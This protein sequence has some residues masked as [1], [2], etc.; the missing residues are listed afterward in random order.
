MF[1]LK[2]IISVDI[3]LHYSKRNNPVIYF[4]YWT[5]STNK[6]FEAFYI[7]GRK[8]IF[9]K[10]QPFVL[11][12]VLKWKSYIN[13]INCFFFLFFFKL[14]L[15][16]YHKSFRLFAVERWFIVKFSSS[17]INLGSTFIICY[18]RLAIKVQIQQQLWHWSSQRCINAARTKIELQKDTWSMGYGICYMKRGSEVYL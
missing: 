8:F 3:I 10:H 13:S 6:P 12:S 17:D 11:Y 2:N 1:Y 15:C 18:A 9:S 16:S 4:K 14:T 7:E 5:L